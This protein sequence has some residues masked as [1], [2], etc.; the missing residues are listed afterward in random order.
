MPFPEAD[1]RR[2]LQELRA[3]DARVG[4][5]WH[6]TQASPPIAEGDLVTAA[7]ARRFRLAWPPAFPF[8]PPNLWELDDVG[9]VVDHRP[10]GHAF[11]DASICLFAHTPEFGWK[12]ELTAANAL[13]RLRG[14]LEASDRSA[15]PRVDVLPVEVPFVRISI[16]PTLM[17]VLRTNGSFGV[18]SGFHR[19]DGRF[20]LITEAQVTTPGGLATG[21]AGE[22]LPERWLKSLGLVE[23]WHGF[24][25]RVD[26]SLGDDPPTQ[27]RFSSWLAEQVL[28]DKA[29][30][31]ILEQPALLLIGEPDV[32][33][34]WLQPPRRIAQATGDRVLFIVPAEE[35]IPE[36]LFSRADAR[37]DN[38]AHLRSARVAVVGTGSLGGTVAL[39]LAKAGVGRF[40]L[41]DGEGLEPENVVRHVGG[42]RDVGLPKVDAVARAI[43]R[44]NPDAEVVPV[45]TAL[46]LDPADWHFDAVKHLD[47]V[48]ADPLGV[49][50]CATASA[51]VEHVVNAMCMARGVPA[52]YGAVLGDAEHARVFR[53]L[54]RETPCYA[55]VL[56]A[57]WRDSKRFPRFERAD[58]GAPA[59][60]AGGFPGLGIDVDEI[61]MMTA[62]LTLQTIALRIP[63]GIGYPAAHGDH[64]I[65]SA[66]G[67]WVVDGPLQARVERME[68][69]PDCPVC[70]PR[71]TSPLDHRERDQLD[72]L[73]ARVARSSGVSEDE[74]K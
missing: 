44:V 58:V 47:E 69:Q 66:R 5:A 71:A 23:P 8:R 24:W 40:T 6:L 54:P 11:S 31:A 36:K 65:W 55:C 72:A 39:A 30:Q 49:V 35:A 53:V 10:S 9:N 46:S 3:L 26:R 4:T 25:C 21:T 63:G 15:F 57:Q 51:D 28:S 70:G 12:P 48:L 20:A 37:L 27:A 68:R 19:E 34:V 18:M 22:P 59:Y 52:V 73:L 56:L 29:R 45:R 67:G 64:F 62:R 60:A 16:H 42:L 50:V 33:F 74:P 17:A 61:A 32:R 41:F 43:A 38:S 7:G 2:W 13:D 1:P 14:F